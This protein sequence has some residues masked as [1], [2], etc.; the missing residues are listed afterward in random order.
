MV[1]AEVPLSGP[2]RR[3]KR[4]TGPGWVAGRWKGESLR[5]ARRVRNNGKGVLNYEDCRR[6]VL[7]EG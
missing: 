6:T 3:S 2:V 7:G 5:A 4:L 1:G